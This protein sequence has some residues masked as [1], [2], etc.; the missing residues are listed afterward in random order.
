LPATPKAKRT[1][2]AFETVL[3]KRFSASWRLRASYTYSQ[4]R[5]LY[6]GL[7]SSDEEGRQS[8]N[9]DRDFDLWFLSRDANQRTVDGPLQTDRP[10]Q[11]KVDANYSAPWGTNLGVFFQGLSGRPISRTADINNINLL[12]ANR[13]SDGR[14]PFTTQT[15]LYVAHNFEIGEGK[16]IQVN[17]NI[18]NLFN[19]KEVNDTFREMLRSSLSVDIEPGQA[20]DYNSLINDAAADDPYLKD[21]RFLKANGFQAPIEARFGLRFLF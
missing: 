19:Q 16:A 1:Y 4:L 21:S 9:V 18:E 17:F 7:A 20:Y 14:M 6:S 2:N 8:P 11:F 13:G 12:V 10:N 3:T 5:G 15:D